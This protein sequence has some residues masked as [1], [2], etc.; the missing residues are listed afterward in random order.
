MANGFTSQRLI[1]ALGFVALFA[2]CARTP[3][4]SATFDPAKLNGV[5][6]YEHALDDGSLTEHLQLRDPRLSQY[7][8]KLWRA[9]NLS[10]STTLLG[11][12]GS[13]SGATNRIHVVFVG[14]GYTE[15]E[16]WQYHKDVKAALAALL[17][18]EPF[19]SYR[20]FFKFDVV[21]VISEESGVSEEKPGVK[22]KTA[23][24]MS[25]NCEGIERLLC[26]N[27]ESA[28]REALN[29]GRVDVV[30][31]LANSAKYGGAGYMNPRIST[32]GAR[33]PKSLEIALHEFG[34]SFGLLTDEYDYGDL[35]EECAKFANSADVEREQMLHDQV[36]WWRWL[37]QPNV[38][39]F[40]GAC[41]TPNHFRPTENSKMR[42][43]GLPFEQINT[44]QLIIKVYERV[45]MI[46]SATP[47]TA[48]KGNKVFKL[49]LV[50]PESHRLTVE[51]FV[52]D[53]Q[54]IELNG[55]T[56]FDSKKLRLKP[57]SYTVRVRVSDRTDQVRDPAARAQLLTQELTYSLS[58]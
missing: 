15:D 28:V 8:R 27:Q 37:D 54:M 38:G 36:K 22:K 4:S 18:Q 26:I 23:L 40:K 53:K 44:E 55:S 32:M 16:L 58:L 25:Y 6:H 52:N 31:A 48:S 57:G 43:L 49:K 35:P 1:T 50:Q 45:R 5:V 42:Q 14:D 2:S 29:A 30:F 47:V 3:Q 11:G 17:S 51:W 56:K 9:S 33:N 13:Q 19:K 10:Q 12:D 7:D 39:T 34:H 46:D 20:S 21:D 24:E 41:Y